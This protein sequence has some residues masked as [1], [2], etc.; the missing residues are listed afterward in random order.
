MR[1][2]ETV[3]LRVI[4]IMFPK[5]ELCLQYF[6]KAPEAKGLMHTF[7]VNCKCTGQVII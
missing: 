6:E 5:Y 7:S 3:N 1:D 4:N 2:L